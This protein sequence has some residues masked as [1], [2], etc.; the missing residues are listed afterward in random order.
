MVNDN[1]YFYCYSMKMFKFLRLDKGINYICCG[2]HE[3]TSMKFWQFK[4]TVE[5]TKAINEYSKS[6]QQDV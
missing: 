2:L 1:D 3:K 4:R 5:L 6:Y